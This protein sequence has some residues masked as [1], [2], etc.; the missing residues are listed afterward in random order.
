MKRQREFRLCR[1]R[2]AGVQ[3]KAAEVQTVP[4][5]AVQSSFF[6]ANFCPGKEAAAGNTLCISKAN[7]AAWAKIRP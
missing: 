4:R 1:G 7:D 5:S 2:A 6:G 3:A